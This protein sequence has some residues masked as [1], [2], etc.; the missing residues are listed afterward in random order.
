MTAPL[1]NLPRRG[2]VGLAFDPAASECRIDRVQ[3]SGPAARAGVAPGDILLA[4]GDT[5]VADATAARAALV[6]CRAGVALS[7]TF[8][9][10]HEALTVSLVPDPMP[11]E[12]E[13]RHAVSYRAVDAGGFRLRVLVH[14]PQG[15]GPWPAVLFLAGSD[16]GSVERPDARDPL[17][18]LVHD[19]VDAGYAVV[20]MERRGVGDSE[21]P[22]LADATLAD[23]RDDYRAALRWLAAEPWCAPGRVV[24]L[25]HSLGGL[26]APQ[27]CATPEGAAVR[28]MMLYGVGSLPWTEYLARHLRA[29]GALQGLDADAID[30]LYARHRQ[31]H[32]RLLEARQSLGEFFDAVPEARAHPARYGLDHA[33]RIEGRCVAYWQEVPA[34]PTIEPLCTAARPTRIAWGACDWQSYRDEHVALAEALNAVHA[35]LATFVEVPEADHNFALRAGRDDAFVRWGGGPYAPAVGEAFTA[36]LRTL[37]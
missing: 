18:C 23:E 17:R 3:P 15:D 10:P 30:A 28:A 34:S 25:G 19:L 11:L 22:P 16:L 33:G 26:L 21:G 6:R 27:L 29:V 8:A 13:A 9:R 36:W 20:R 7:L 31:M 14:Y 4:V 12:A 35:G 32:T 1:D 24:L 2:R 37:G 5:P